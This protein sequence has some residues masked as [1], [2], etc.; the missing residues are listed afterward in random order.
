MSV[1]L[2]LI[3]AMGMLAV[4]VAAVAEPAENGLKA[5]E[6]RY[7]LARNGKPQ[8]QSLLRLRQLGEGRWELSM[9]IEANRGLAGL[10]GYRESE[11]SLLE[12]HAEGWRVSEY[13]RERGTGFSRRNEQARF[14]WA[15][16]TALVLHDG[17]N[18]ELMVE[19]GTVDPGSLSLLVAAEL[20][21]G[22]AL[23]SY[24]VLR[25]G[26]VERW[27][28]RVLREEH[29]AGRA[30]TVVERVREHQ[31]R[32]TISWLGEDIGYLPVRIEQT[33]DGDSIVMSLDAFEWIDAGSAAEGEERAEG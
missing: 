20:R 30:T 26:Q 3:L 15:S 22:R 32:S 12:E 18:I 25:K 29:L 16:G 6:A 8:G 33:E 21:A 28:F 11:T 4:P 24:P 19:E 27:P 17:K 1:A 9:T 7:S 31:R 13:R 10:V 23:D 14:D 5:F 2:R